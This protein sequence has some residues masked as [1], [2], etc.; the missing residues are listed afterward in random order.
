[1]KIYTLIPKE[2]RRIRRGTLDL[3]QDEVAKKLGVSKNT[4]VV[5]EQGK[6]Q[7]EPANLIKLVKLFGEG[8]LKEIDA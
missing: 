1:M 7:P 6:G 3:Y 5:W 8:I 4:Y 2:M